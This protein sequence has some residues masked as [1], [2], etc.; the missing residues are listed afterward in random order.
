[1]HETLT[2]GFPIAPGTDLTQ[3]EHIQC[4]HPKHGFVL[5]AHRVAG[6]KQTPVRWTY[7]V[8]GSSEQWRDLGWNMDG[9]RETYSTNELIEFAKRAGFGEW[10]QSPI[11]WVSAYP[12]DSLD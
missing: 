1:M 6:D 5:R 9:G 7:V 4:T 10:E 11:D 12:L 8:E 3:Y 2:D